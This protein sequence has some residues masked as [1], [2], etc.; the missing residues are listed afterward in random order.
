MPTPIWCC[1]FAVLYRPDS[2][3]MILRPRDGGPGL[4]SPEHS[5]HTGP[6]INNVLCSL[7][8]L[9]WTTIW[10]GTRVTPIRTGRGSSPSAQGQRK[11]WRVASFRASCSF[12]ISLGRWSCWRDSSPDPDRG[13]LTSLKVVYEGVMVSG[14]PLGTLARENL[15][16][17]RQCSVILQRWALAR[18]TNRVT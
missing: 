6:V 18:Y 16:C 8:S 2:R 5:V 13:H 12:G 17:E 1:P 4:P 10:L 11:H 14:M 7:Y 3:E 9:I 15:L